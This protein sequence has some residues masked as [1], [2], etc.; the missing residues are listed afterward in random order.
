VILNYCLCFR[1]DLRLTLYLCIHSIQNGVETRCFT[2]NALEYTIMEVQ[3]TLG[4]HG[5]HT[6][7]VPLR[8]LIYWMITY[9]RSQGVEVMQRN[10]A[11]VLVTK[12]SSF[13]SYKYM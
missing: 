9:E 8:D 3:E 13:E 5:T 6:S 2:I 4:L 1:R 10:Y 7:S 12:K 11:Y